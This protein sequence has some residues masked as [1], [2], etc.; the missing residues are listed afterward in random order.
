M[1][2]I[3][4]LMFNGNAEEAMNFY[5]TA[6]GGSIESLQRYGESPMP[7]EEHQKG[8][9]LHAIFHVHGTKMMCSDGDGK[10]KLIMG[11]N[12]SLSLDFDSEEKIEETFTKLSEGG[13]VTMPL[14]DTFWNARFGMCTDKF[15]INWMFNY[16]RPQQA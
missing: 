14:Q 10:Q 7:V 15:G 3:I 9:V 5:T 16:D 4:Y 1:S 11:D 6:T 8:K 13:N 2:M 12:I